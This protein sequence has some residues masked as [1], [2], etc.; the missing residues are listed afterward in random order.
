MSLGHRGHQFEGGTGQPP[1]VVPV[2]GASVV[3]ELLVDELG[4]V[5]R[6]EVDDDGPTGDDDL[7]LLEPAAVATTVPS[8]GR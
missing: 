4:W 8:Q 5:V 2:T 3:D 6:V 7:V 1:G